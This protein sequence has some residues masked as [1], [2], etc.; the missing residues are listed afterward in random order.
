M[1]NVESAGPST[2]SPAKRRRW[3]A[4]LR[5]FAVHIRSRYR[6]AGPGRRVL[7]IAAVMVAIGLHK[8]INLLVLTGYCLLAVVVLNA[9]AAGRRLPGLRVRR[10]Q[11]DAPV[12]G[13]PFEAEVEVINLLPRPRPGF[14]LEETGASPG[15]TFRAPPL[16]AHGGCL[17]AQPTGAASPGPSHLRRARGRER[18]PVWAS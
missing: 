4:R 5:S 15:L 7:V 17:L 11:P 10:R 14:R 9:R 12:A 1:R 3:T 16:E 2:Y 8:G 18:L 6:L 13:V